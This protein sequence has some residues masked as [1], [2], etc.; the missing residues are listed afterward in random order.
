MIKVKFTH[1]LLLQLGPSYP[2]AHTHETK[3]PFSTIIEFTEHFVGSAFLFYQCRF[4]SSKIEGFKDTFILLMNYDKILSKN[5][6][7]Y[8]GNK[9]IFKSSIFG[10]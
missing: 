4:Y 2:E 5:F 9:R 10:E 1:S 3:Q 6:N 7:C 8:Y